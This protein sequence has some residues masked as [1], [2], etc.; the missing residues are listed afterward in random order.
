MSILRTALY[1][2]LSKDDMLQGDSESI[3]TQKAML[4]QYAKEH[5]F[6]IVEVYVDDGWSGLNFQRPDFNRMLDDIEAGKIDVVIT[7]DLS[8]LGRDHLKVGH[9]TE[10]YFPMKNVR[11]IAVND[12]VDTANKNNDIAALKNVMNEFYSRDNSRKIRSSIRARAKAGLYRTSFNPI[13]YRKSPDNHNKLIVDGETAWIVKR[14]FELANAGMGAHKIA[15]T[16]REEQVPCPSWWLHSRGERDYSQRFENPANKYEWSHTVIRNII[17]N[18]LYLGHTVMCK[19]ESIF[20]VGTF[21][22]VPKADQIRVENTHEPLVSQELFDGANAKILSRRR[23][24]TDNFVSPFSGLVK[25]GTCGKALGLRYWGKDRHHIYVCTTYAHDTK[26]CSD[27]RI[28]YEDLYNAVLADIQYHARLAYEDRDKAVALAMKMNAK[29]DGNKGK[30]NE[31]KLKQAKKRYDEV[32]RLFDRLYEDSLSGRIS[33]DNF[34]RLI[35]KYQTEQEQ[36]LGQIQNLE[37]ALQEVKDSQTNAVQWAALMADYVGIREL[38]AENLNLLVERIEVFDRTETD[39]EAEQVIRIC[40]RFGGYIGERR[41]K[42]KVLRN[43]GGWE[44]RRRKERK[45]D[46]KISFVS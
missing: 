12:G 25:C 28:Y 39:G 44:R 13:G 31:S 9:F 40:Y 5:G 4:T 34:T 23:D 15:K 46:G 20:K 27:H 7:K 45:D 36:L 10:I 41:F 11:Y 18:P 33:N 1:C 22:K 24:T 29:A 35:D 17:A 3:K 38:T 8:R 30:S 32:T 21:K 6:L 43:T 26:A 16:F 14:I 19:T 2:R 42:A 37:N